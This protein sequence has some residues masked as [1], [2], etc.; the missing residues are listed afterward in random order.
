MQSYMEDRGSNGRPTTY[1]AVD[2]GN[3]E[4][5]NRRN[6]LLENPA[7]VLHQTTLIDTDPGLTATSASTREGKAS[8]AATAGL[9]CK[10]RFPHLLSNTSDL[11]RLLGHR[12]RPL[13]LRCNQLQI[14][15]GVVQVPRGCT[16]FALVRKVMEEAERKKGL[17]FNL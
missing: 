3:D 7:K 10:D 8:R 14:V 17:Q 4:R 13:P 11:M 9:R 5:V 2:S 6:V 16:K 12:S 1:Y 15:K